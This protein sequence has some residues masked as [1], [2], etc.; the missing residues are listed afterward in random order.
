[1]VTDVSVHG[2]E[3]INSQQLDAGKYVGRQV[4]T[5]VVEVRV[6]PSRGSNHIKVTGDEAVMLMCGR[7]ADRIMLLSGWLAR[8]AQGGRYHSL[9]HGRY[10]FNKKLSR[11]VH[12]LPKNDAGLVRQMD[13]TLGGTWLSKKERTCSCY[14]GP[15]QKG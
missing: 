5:K 13:K 4:H 9:M 8:Q 12:F 2:K 15:A 6:S 14:Q 1:M 10:K 3:L 7:K 11:L